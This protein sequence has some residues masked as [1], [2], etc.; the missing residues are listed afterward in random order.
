MGRRLAGLALIVVGALSVAVGALGIALDSGEGEA[1]AP[2]PSPTASP[3]GSPAAS[4]AEATTPP[5]TPS[6][7][8]ES[9]EE[10]LRAFARAFRTGEEDFLLDRL[11]PAV[12][13]LYGE[14]QCRA[15]VAGIQDRTAEFTQQ[16]VE[17]PTVFRWKVDGS[18]TRV[19]DVL[20]VT[21]TRIREG[22]ETTQ[23]IHLGIVEGTLRWFTDCGE[24]SS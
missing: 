15:F 19:E 4:P 22:E 23:E 12:I 14:E 3:A 6:P 7:E 5:A 16:S 1:S 21:I 20:T 10:F 17:G 8:V 13:D 2:S 11:H 24:P 9:L 18:V